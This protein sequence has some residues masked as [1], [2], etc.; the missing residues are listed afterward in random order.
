MKPK[1]IFNI[2]FACISTA[3]CLRNDP[4]IVIIGAGPAGIA[5]ATRL[6]ERG[7]KNVTVLEAEPRIGGRIHSVKFGEAFVDLG[8]Q[9]C[10]GE[11]DNIVY[12]LV[13]DLDILRR[14]V[15]SRKLYHSSGKSLDEEFAGEILDIMDSVYTADGNRMVADYVTVGDFCV[16]K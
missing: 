3:L 4:S 15:T 8:A 1:P 11:E 12:D 6:L 2:L 9:W 13:K 16:Q 10:H 14:S 7:F 5:T